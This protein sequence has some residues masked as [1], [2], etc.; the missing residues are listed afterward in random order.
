MDDLPPDF[1]LL[2]FSTSDFAPALRLAAWSEIMRRKLLALQIEPAG[3]GKAFAADV[4]MRGLLDVRIA[5]GRIGATRSARTA[6]LAARDND[7]VILL[8]GV[9]G[10]IGVTHQD[11]AHCLRSGDAVLF[12]C[13]QEVSFL[14]GAPV[15]TLL[16]RIPLGM[17]ARYGRRDGLAGL[18]IIRGQTSELT[19]LIRYV[20]TLFEGSEIAMSPG[21]SRVVVDHIVDLV[22][23]TVGVPRA[24]DFLAESPDDGAARLHVIKADIL[25]NLAWRSLSIRWL[26]GRHGLG[27]RQL[28]RL[29]EQAGMPFGEFVLEQRLI[30][31]H[32]MIRN[33]RFSDLGIGEIALQCGFGDISYFN[34]RFRA[35]YG[36][37]PSV[38]RGRKTKPRSA[39]AAAPP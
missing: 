15:Q 39:F 26:A 31:A 2:R 7:D 32:G 12:G 30:A 25:H 38:V 8:A 35:R 3:G 18:R 13:S 16:I 10:E 28:Y 33:P 22:A 37:T 21:A 20:A 34:Q 19:L 23:L 36:A 9:D 24:P 14:L 29:F 1:R 6:Q 17:L 27:A 11:R 4:M 5:T